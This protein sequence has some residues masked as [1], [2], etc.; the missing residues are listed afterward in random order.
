M[1][2]IPTTIRAF[3]D[4]R[5]PLLIYLFSIGNFLPPLTVAS[6]RLMSMVLGWGALFSFLIVYIKRFPLP[7][8]HWPIFYPLLF[9]LVLCSSWRWIQEPDSHRPFDGRGG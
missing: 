8:I 7:V 3:D 1:D 6:A 4:Y 9:V 2:I 5:P